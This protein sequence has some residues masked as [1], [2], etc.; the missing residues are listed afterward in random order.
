[1]HASHGHDGDQHAPSLAWI[2]EEMSPFAGLLFFSFGGGLGSDLEIFLFPEE[3][4]LIVIME[5][6]ED[7]SGFLMPIL[8]DH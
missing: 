6:C 1:M 7:H 4:I 3:R 2:G 5:S 8:G